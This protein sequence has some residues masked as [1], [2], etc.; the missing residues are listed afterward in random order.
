MCSLKYAHTTCP[1][2]QLVHDESRSRNAAG[3]ADESYNS[4]E[5]YCYPQRSICSIL[6][7]SVVHALF[8]LVLCKTAGP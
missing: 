7:T 8:F 3:G 4:D 5:R 6:N 2:P 1:A